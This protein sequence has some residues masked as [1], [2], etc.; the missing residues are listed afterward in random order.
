M[1]AEKKISKKDLWFGKDF[2][3]DLITSPAAYLL[4]FPIFLALIISIYFF[5]DFIKFNERLSLVIAIILL[6]FVI[7]EVLFRIFK[8]QRFWI[9]D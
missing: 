4:T 7:V 1:L 6:A 5:L 3:L 8:K 2:W 9:K